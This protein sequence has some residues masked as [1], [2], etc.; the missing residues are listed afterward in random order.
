MGLIDVV[1]LVAWSTIAA[2]L[3]YAGQD[4]RERTS[5]LDS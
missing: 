3:A 5:T 4:E 1:A 2:Y